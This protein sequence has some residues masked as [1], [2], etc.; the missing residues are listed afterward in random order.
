MVL[1]KEREVYKMTKGKKIIIAI[2]AVLFLWGLSHTKVM[3]YVPEQEII[4]TR[5]ILGQIIDIEENVD[6]NTYT[7]RAN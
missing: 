7:L 1:I 6:Y 4:I 2:I 3:T 5:N